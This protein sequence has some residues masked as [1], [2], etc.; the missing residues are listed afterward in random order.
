MYPLLRTFLGLNISQ[1]QHITEL[2]LFG[3]YRL[4]LFS[5]TEYKG[6]SYQGI[7]VFCGLKKRILLDFFSLQ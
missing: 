1:V 3:I 5:D 6:V 7:V 2:A 4:R